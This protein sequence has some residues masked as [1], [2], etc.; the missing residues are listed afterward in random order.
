ME[1]RDSSLFFIREIRDEI[2]DSSRDEIR[3]KL[4]T[5]PYFL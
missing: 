2:R 4:G 5:A 3:T 1:I